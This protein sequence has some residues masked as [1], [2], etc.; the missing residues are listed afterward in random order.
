MKKIQ[1][2]G[3]VVLMAVSS[4]AMA[5][6]KRDKNSDL[7]KVLWDADQEW[8]CAGP[9]FKPPKECVEQRAIFWGE[10]FFEVVGGGNVLSKAEMVSS[11]TALAPKN[12]SGV[13][14]NGVFPGDFKLR[15][16]YGKFAVATDRT[17]FKTLDA[18]GLPAFTST[19][20]WLRLFVYENGR[21][22]PAA[23]AGVPVVPFATTST[24]S[25]QTS[26]SGANHR[27]PNEQLEKELAAIDTK[28]LDSAMHQKWD[29][30]DELFT[31]HWFEILGWDPTTDV[32]KEFA[33]EAIMRPRPNAKPGEGVV[34]DQFQLWA[35]YGDVALATDRRTRHWT[36]AKGNSVVTPHRSL[37]VFV[38]QDGQ[39]KSAATALAPYVAP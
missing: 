33:R 37:L 26:N 14:L 38:K 23:G 9:Y 16:V 24:S 19:M 21:W 28:W 11:Q 22:R 8:L 3:L 20:K 17:A 4:V 36:D 18:N 32:N 2:L 34:P 31:D 29:Y 5:Q 12:A 39:W 35:D 10:Q 25:Q 13:S 15:A 27:S 6:S 7:E 30:L 1:M